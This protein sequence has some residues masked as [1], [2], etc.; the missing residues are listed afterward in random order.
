MPSFLLNKYFIVAIISVGLVAGTWYAVDDICFKPQ[1]EMEKEL[2]SIGEY[3]NISE[4]KLTVCE[5]K[6][7]KNTLEGLV[8]G[9]HEGDDENITIDLDDSWY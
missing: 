8:E 6:L 3:L 5:A 1:R 7:G 9:L 4:A 2:Q